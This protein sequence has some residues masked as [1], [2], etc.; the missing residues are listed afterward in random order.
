M[1][2]GHPL[3]R[4]AVSFAA[5]LSAP[6]MTI[7]SADEVAGKGLLR[8]DQW[9]DFELGWLANRIERSRLFYMTEGVVRY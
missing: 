5:R 1:N 4:A 2:S 7:L 9:T 3:A 6:A 8:A